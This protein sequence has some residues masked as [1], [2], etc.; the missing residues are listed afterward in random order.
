[1]YKDTKTA[2]LIARSHAQITAYFD[3]MTLLGPGLVPVKAWRPEPD[4]P[5]DID[6][7]I[8]GLLGALGTLPPP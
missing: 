5:P 8:P 1:M 7:T 4:R 3:G 6:L 2:A